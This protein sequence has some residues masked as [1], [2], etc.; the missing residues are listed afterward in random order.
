MDDL[1]FDELGRA[2]VRL[3]KLGPLLDELI[4]PR[5]AASGENAGLA[6]VAKGS[7]PPV[8]VTML[9]LKIQTEDI[10]GWWCARVVEA[11]PEVGSVPS[12]RSVVA[13]ASWLRAHLDEFELMPSAELGASDLV[14]QARWVS[15]VVDPPASVDAPAPVEVGSVSV[16]VS[17]A[18]HLGVKISA[19]TVR[20]WCQTGELAYST[21]LDG[22]MQVALT[23][24]LSRARKTGRD[25]GTH[26][27]CRRG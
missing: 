24:V 6:P 26:G 9:D 4:V 17:W 14:T 18:R 1:L 2:L 23:D 5:Q 16:V 22:C 19:R 7:R 3:E 20:H 11:S 12:D 15:D 8:S 10:L 27:F 13:R 21:G 25:L